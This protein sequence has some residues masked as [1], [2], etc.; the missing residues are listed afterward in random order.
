MFGVRELIG[1]LPKFV[2][3]PY[4]PNLI[5]RIICLRT[6][7]NNNKDNRI[8]LDKHNTVH[9]H[10]VATTIHQ[11]VV[12]PSEIRYYNRGR[13]R[14]TNRGAELSAADCSDTFCSSKSY[15]ALSY[16]VLFKALYFSL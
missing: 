4:R 13:E 15:T 7:D 11:L 2:S 9:N 10:M 6:V 16:F 14:E 12:H 3:D 5:N 8:S 1:L